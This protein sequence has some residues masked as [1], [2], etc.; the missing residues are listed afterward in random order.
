MCFEIAIFFNLLSPHFIWIKFYL[1]TYYYYY[2]TMCLNA[3]KLILLLRYIGK[4]FNINFW[5][6]WKYLNSFE[7]YFI[8][9]EIINSCIKR[10]T[11]KMVHKILN[12]FVKMK[13]KTLSL[14]E[15]L[16]VGQMSWYRKKGRI[17]II[18]TEVKLLVTIIT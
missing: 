16:N 14:C 4:F 8:G 7:L 10:K 15:H 18:K 3:R 6:E 9:I 17:D 11:L 12:V 13:L 2:L 5:Y 1:S